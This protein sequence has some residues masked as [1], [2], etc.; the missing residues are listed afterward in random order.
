MR[1][2]MTQTVLVVPLLPCDAAEWHQKM[3]RAKQITQEQYLSHLN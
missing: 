2:G 3:A 1:K